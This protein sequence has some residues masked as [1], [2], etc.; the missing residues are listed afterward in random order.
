MPAAVWLD[1][2]TAPHHYSWSCF[3]RKLVRGK[4]SRCRVVKMLRCRVV[5]MLSFPDVKMWICQDVE[6]SRCWDVELS[7]CQVVELSRCWDVAMLGFRVVKMLRCWVV[8]NSTSRHLYNSWQVKKLHAPYR[9]PYD[10]LFGLKAHT[11][12]CPN[13]TMFSHGVKFCYCFICISDSDAKTSSSYL[14]VIPYS[15][16]FQVILNCLQYVSY[17][18]SLYT[19]I[20]FHCL[21]EMEFQHIPLESARRV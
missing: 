9:V 4:L 18:S 19:L 15:E 17:T 20:V 14:G 10:S 13:M 2:S 5:E 12:S 16:V 11:W 21:V 7:G 8:D 3:F 1:Y 6:L